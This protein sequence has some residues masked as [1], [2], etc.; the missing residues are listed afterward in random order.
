MWSK[1][2]VG[3]EIFSLKKLESNQTFSKKKL[4]LT[5][6]L[7]EKNW[8]KKSLNKKDFWVL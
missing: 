4:G 3:P 7:V 1:N 5:N 8:I 2:F 6:Y